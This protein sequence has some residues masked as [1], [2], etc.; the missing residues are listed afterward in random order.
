MYFLCFTFWLI[1]FL[2]IKKKKNQNGQRDDA[3]KILNLDSYSTHLSSIS[4]YKTRSC[5]GGKM[6]VFLLHFLFGS[7][8]FNSIFF[9]L[10]DWYLLKCIYLL[11]NYTSSIAYYTFLGWNKSMDS[12]E[13][14][15]L[16]GGRIL[17]I[18]CV[19]S[20]IN[21]SWLLF[22]SVLTAVAVMFHMI[23]YAYCL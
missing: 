7:C 19:F 1:K 12:D 15:S 5:G 6:L 3:T 9:P 4:G 14:L 21:K 10:F 23:N 18:L 13:N 2:F 17:I 22:P 20:Y 11:L 8:H 16:L